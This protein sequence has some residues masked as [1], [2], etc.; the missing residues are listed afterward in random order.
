MRDIHYA[1]K[2][3]HQMPPILLK[4]DHEAW[5]GGSRDE[6]RS[7]LEPDPADSM[8][9]YAVLELTATFYAYANTNLSADL[10]RSGDTSQNEIWQFVI[11]GACMRRRMPQVPVPRRRAAHLLCGAPRFAHGVRPLLPPLPLKNDGSEQANQA[12][13]TRDNCFIQ[14]PSVDSGQLSRSIAREEGA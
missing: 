1:G 6:P 8:Y 13:A 3:S 9:P 11:S 2:I 7:L 4:E 5:L 14:C 12:A 10:Y